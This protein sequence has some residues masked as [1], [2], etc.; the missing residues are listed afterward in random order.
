MPPFTLEAP[1]RSPLHTRKPQ[2]MYTKNVYGEGI[3][4][5]NWQTVYEQIP[6]DVNPLCQGKVNH[7]L[8][9]YRRFGTEEGDIGTSTTQEMMKQVFTENKLFPDK[10]MNCYYTYTEYVIIFCELVK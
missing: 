2:L 7:F 3:K 10:L 5:K 6:F 9:H 8:S 1:K 4:V